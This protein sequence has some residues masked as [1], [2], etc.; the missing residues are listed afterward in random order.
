MQASI[1]ATGGGCELVT[2]L[3]L[4]AIVACRED[5]LAIFRRDGKG[6]SALS[7]S[8]IRKKII[9]RQMSHEML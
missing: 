4:H 3:V 6:C 2:N 7:V 5:K 9:S 1:Y 8:P